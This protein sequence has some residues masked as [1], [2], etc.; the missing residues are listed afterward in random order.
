[1]SG[2]RGGDMEKARAGKRTTVEM[3]E[4]DGL[5]PKQRAFVREYLVDRNATRAA[6]RAGY[7][8]HTANEQSSELL[9]KPNIKEL[10]AE[11]ERRLAEA[12]DVDAAMVISELRQVATADP[13]DLVSVHRGACRYCWGLE[14]DRQWTAGE[15]RD[16]WHE[17]LADD[18][19]A[20]APP[21]RG[22]LG[23]D[24]TRTANPECPECRGF[25]TERVFVND[26]RRL[27]KAAAKLIAG[28][29]QT[30]DGIEYRV[31]DQD[32]ALLA[33]GKVC[34]I[35]VDRQEHSGPGGGPMQLQPVPNFRTMS[36]SELQQFLK[37]N[38]HAV[39]L[40]EGQIKG[41]PQQQ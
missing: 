35:F 13:R 11:K 36:D 6:I 32:G 26:T 25:G 10:V 20:S 33:L 30:R 23:Y 34:G 29:K 22:G 9:A 14:H 1:M 2:K 15:Y 39:P 5:T 21:I 28:V 41:E 3:D 24:F 12:A 40:L 38:G 7:S 4:G 19:N 18:P 17:A 16:A 27:S 37:S 8:P 31:R